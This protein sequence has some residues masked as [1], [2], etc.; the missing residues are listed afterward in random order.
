MPRQPCDDQAGQIYHALNRGNQRQT[1]F[2]KEED[3]LAFERVLAEGLAKYPVN[4]FS[5]T[6]MPN[7]WHLILR[8]GKDHQMGRLLRWVT[9]THTCGIGHTTT[10]SEE[11]TSTKGVSRAL[12]L[13]TMPTF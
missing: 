10:H 8:P 1:L 9:A 12:Q 3:F 5:Y 6:L 13:A 4:L 11:A 7:H 2:H